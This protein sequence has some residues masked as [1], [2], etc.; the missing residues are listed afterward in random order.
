VQVSKYE[1]WNLLKTYILAQSHLVYCLW[2]CKTKNKFTRP[3][4]V[5]QQWNIRI[6]IIYF[7]CTVN[8]VLQLGI[9]LKINRQKLK[10]F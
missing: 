6:Y 8:T 1:S 2:G 4:T 10:H 9:R 7:R 3:I 5:W